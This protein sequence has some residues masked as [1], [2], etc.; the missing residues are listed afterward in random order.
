MT[1][2]QTAWAWNEGD[3]TAEQKL[4]LL[5]ISDGITTQSGIVKKCGKTV[6]PVDKILNFLFAR[7]RITL[8]FPEGEPQYILESLG[9]RREIG[10]EA[11]QKRYLAKK[12]NHGK[13]IG[14]E[15]WLQNHE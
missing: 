12:E 10:F 6:E 9:R 13:A 11:F 4:V 7:Y 5:A 15:A 3:L 14:F 2:E 8:A 1:I